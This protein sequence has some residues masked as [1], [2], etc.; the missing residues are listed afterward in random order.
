[1]LTPQV[2][3]WL[4]LH[5]IGGGGGRE[6]EASCSERGVNFFAVAIRPVLDGNNQRLPSGKMKK[7]VKK[8]STWVIKPAS[9]STNYVTIP[10][11]LLYR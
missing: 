11:M 4:K 5:V 3:L 1:M 9:T 7:M 10:I 2:Q 8:D 6:G